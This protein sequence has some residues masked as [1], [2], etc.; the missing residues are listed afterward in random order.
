VLPPVA[1]TVAVPFAALKQLTSVELV[2][3]AINKLGSLMVAIATAVQPPVPV[4]VTRYCPADR[5]VAVGV[6]CPLLHKYVYGAVPFTPVTVAVP[7]DSPLQLTLV[8]AV[9]VADIPVGSLN[10]TVASFVHPL[11]S[12]TTT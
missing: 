7:L 10:N 2:I 5:F 3:S 1:L 4:T 11:L 8:L 12:V 6:V 9:I